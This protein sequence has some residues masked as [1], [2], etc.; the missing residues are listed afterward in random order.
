VKE[1]G[2]GGR[3]VLGGT[4]LIEGAENLA[5]TESELTRMEEIAPVH[6]K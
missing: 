6:H 5:G 3:I 2:V 4:Q 1:S